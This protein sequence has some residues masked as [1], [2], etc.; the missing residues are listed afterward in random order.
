M[1]EHRPYFAR[2]WCINNTFN[3]ACMCVSVILIFARCWSINNSSEFL[4]VCEHHPYFAGCWS[5]NNISYLCVNTILT[6][7]DV[8]IGERK[9]LSRFVLISVLAHT[10]KTGLL[11]HPPNCQ[12]CWDKE[13]RSY[14]PCPKFCTVVLLSVE[15]TGWYC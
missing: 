10:V 1:C 5:I 3:S 9:L 6:L 14:F 12:G 8:S 15:H 4:L 13:K 7:L 2:C 11:L